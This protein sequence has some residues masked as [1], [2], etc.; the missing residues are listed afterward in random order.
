MTV[1]TYNSLNKIRIYKSLHI[2]NNQEK[3]E[4]P[5]LT[6]E[7]Q[8]INLEGIRESHHFVIIIG[9]VDSG[10]NSNQ[11][12]LKLAVKVWQGIDYS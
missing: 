11:W 9:R 7:C 4:S 2:T 10:K 12:M 6:I 5:F 3:K 8:I 1:L